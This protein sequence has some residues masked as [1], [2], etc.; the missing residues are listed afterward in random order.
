MK[1][2][3]GELGRRVALLYIGIVITSTAVGIL[4]IEVQPL[5][6]VYNLSLSD[7]TSVKVVASDEA[8]A[9]RLYNCW[10]DRRCDYLPT[11]EVTLLDSAK[12]WVIQ[13]GTIAF[14]GFLFVLFP[15]IIFAIVSWLL[16]GLKVQKPEQ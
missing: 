10:L 5:R 15:S 11:Q 2:N 9:S 6:H 14:Q 8:H 12:G 7:G 4:S 13:A 16:A 3:W 1:R